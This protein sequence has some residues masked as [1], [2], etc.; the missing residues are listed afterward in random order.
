MCS[1]PRGDC[2]HGARVL[3]RGIKSD[4]TRDSTLN[5]QSVESSRLSPVAVAQ[6]YPV[7]SATPATKATL[8]FRSTSS[9]I[10]GAI[11]RTADAC[12]GTRVAGAPTN[13]APVEGNRR[14]SMIGGSGEVKARRSLRAPAPAGAGRDAS[15]RQLTFL[16]LAPPSGQP[17]PK[18]GSRRRQWPRGAAAERVRPHS[19]PRPPPTYPHSRA[20]AVAPTLCA[21]NS[22]S[23]WTSKRSGW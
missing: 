19:H 10:C 23:G 9:A 11:A 14:E 2:Y 21:G 13:M 1:G 16:P 3:G 6:P 5:R 7:E 20:H 12:V 8:P 17:P 4:L 18:N 15:A 22:M